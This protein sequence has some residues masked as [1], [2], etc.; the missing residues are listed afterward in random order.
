MGEKLTP[1]EKV[2]L[3][4]NLDRPHITDFIDA[5]F[6]DFFEQKG[7]HLCDD[8]SSIYGGVALF[9]GIPVSIVGHRKGH[10]VYEQLKYNCGMTKPEGYR[11]A[12]RIMKQAE[13]FNR[14]IITFVD[15]PGAYPG[16]EAEEHGQGE[17]IAQS[18]AT[19]SALTVPVICAVTGEGN[20]G[21]A[22]ALSVA[23]E[24]YMLENAVYSVLSPEGFASILW[25]DSTKSPEACDLLKLTADD[26]Y[27]TGIIDE[28]I[29]E[30][31]GGAK[32]DSISVYDEI[33]N[34]L[35][36]DLKKYMKMTKEEIVRYRRKKFR[37]I[38][39]YELNRQLKIS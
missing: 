33:S 16:K 13:K 35:E 1:N 36:H 8:D 24:I 6:T 22:L 12:L 30:P 14:P 9:K 38:C 28:I 39:G 32:V 34:H 10:D 25:K 29:A 18:L 20:S 2:H 3:A 17:A 19:M 15:T 37:E 27:D 7:D 31:Q 11:K 21:G 4:R 23:N 26:L 5:I